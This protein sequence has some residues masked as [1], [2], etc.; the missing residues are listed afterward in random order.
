[1]SR[2]SR[3][4]V[5]SG[6][7]TG[8]G[9]AIAGRFAAAGDIV[10]IL[11]R[12]SEVLEKAAASLGET[13]RTCAVDLTDPDAVEAFAARLTAVDVVVANAGAAPARA[14]GEGLAAVA[15]AWRSTWEANVLTAVLLV[16]A[17]RARLARPGG[18]VVLLSSIAAQRGGGGSYSAAKSALH[19]WAFDLAGDLGPDG[20]T[21]N[22]VVPGFVED[23]EFFGGRMTEERH[24]RLVSQTMVGRAGRPDDVAAAVAY[25]ASPEASWVTGQVLGV[26][27]GAMVG[28]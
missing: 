20:I 21:V 6:G 19:G 5:V 1:M 22:V 16:E 18:R 26:N 24:R 27:G 23:T 25:L 13:V 15:G 12:R 3:T 28:R 11:G 8:I 10:W 9:K 17:L 14:D 4:V 7:G 2:T